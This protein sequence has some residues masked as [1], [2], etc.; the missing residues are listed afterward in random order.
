[1]RINL[2]LGYRRVSPFLGFCGV[3]AT[4]TGVQAQESKPGVLIDKVVLRFTS[5][6]TGGSEKPQFVFEREL[7][8]AARLE[9]LADREYRPQDNQAFAERH[10]RGAL[11]VQIAETLLGSHEVYPPI[12][13]KELKVRIRAAK[14][15][16]LQRVG[17]TIVLQAAADA[18]GVSSAEQ[19]RWLER[20]ARASLYLDRMVAPMLTPGETEL[21]IAHRTT[22]TPFFGKPYH[23]ISAALR[24][25]Y[26]AQRLR[27]AVRAFYEGARTRVSV[28][29]STS[30]R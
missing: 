28:I 26:V 4:V 10:V 3:L 30:T 29:I 8:F 6:D 23:R 14:S 7:A 18:E 19:T 15:A 5:P 16:L 12:E 27:V 13:A 17:G 1:M 20:R 24:R 11:E 9:A 2:G 25:W 22:R 21:R